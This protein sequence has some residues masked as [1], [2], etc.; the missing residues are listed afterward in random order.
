M[1][2]TP[3]YRCRNCNKRY[4]GNKQEISTAPAD[5]LIRAARFTLGSPEHVFRFGG[6]SFQL[7]DLHQCNAN[8]IGIAG[9]IRIQTDKNEDEKKSN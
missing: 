4:Q 3:V 5:S 8:E 9:L 7:S 2:I 1:F 6:K